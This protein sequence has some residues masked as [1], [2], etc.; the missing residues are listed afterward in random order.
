MFNLVLFNFEGF[1]PSEESHFYQHPNQATKSSEVFIE[2][3]SRQTNE[4]IPYYRLR[5]ESLNTY[6]N[7]HWIKAPSKF[8]LDQ[9]LTNDQI[10]LTL[11]YFSKFGLICLSNIAHLSLI[12]LM[13]LQ[14]FWADIELVKWQKRTMI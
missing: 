9:Q 6:K 12:S 4:E 8:L 11:D 7:S 14:K 13:L 10:K 1:Q 2:S 3:S 5:T